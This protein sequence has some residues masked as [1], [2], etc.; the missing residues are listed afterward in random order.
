MNRAAHVLIFSLIALAL[1]MIVQAA[2]IRSPLQSIS[3][4]AG[5]AGS[6]PVDRYYDAIDRFMAGGDERILRDEVSSGF[7]NWTS[8]DPTPADATDFID[9]LST[10][11]TLFPGLV[12]Q[13][14]LLIGGDTQATVQLSASIADRHSL[15]GLAITP[16]ALLG[17]FEILRFE[18]G[19]LA[20]R[21]SFPSVTG[22]FD[23]LAPMAIGDPVS[24]SLSRLTV[25]ENEDDGVTL[26]PAVAM[27][28][29]EGSSIRLTIEGDEN[30][31]GAYLLSSGEWET[32]S[33][34]ATLEL[35]A[36]ALVRLPTGAST[37]VWASTGESSTIVTM[38]LQTADVD[39]F[40]PEPRRFLPVG[41]PIAP[42][43]PVELRGIQRTLQMGRSHLQTGSEFTLDPNSQAMLLLVQDGTL[44]IESPDG[45]R[46]E[47]NEGQA[48]WATP[49]LELTFRVS[50][51]DDASLVLLTFA[52][53]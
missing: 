7:Q 12:L 25:D 8:G 27:L 42:Q 11:R 26:G 50:S 49:A 6:P 31:T 10:L 17:D 9:Q 29:V 33:S 21:W 13:H 30:N 45:A 15:A 22:S 5:P 51:V 53:A 37:H 16:Q 18:R 48:I 34:P 3:R 38:S 36:G 39:R 43:G 1:V 19:R 14:T 40:L 52:A 23:M 28:I 20:E 24:A 32:L 41:E 47:L 35:P 2:L 4:S 44:H 46:M